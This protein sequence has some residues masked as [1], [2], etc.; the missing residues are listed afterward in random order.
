MKGL[1]V[2]NLSGNPVIKK[3]R[4]Y[5]KKMIVRLKRLTYLDD[6]PVF[7]RDRA[8]AEAWDVGGRDAE[9]R[10]H[11]EWNKKDR[12]K[13]DA[14][15]N[16]LRHIREKAEEKRRLEGREMEK[17]TVEPAKMFDYKIEGVDM[18]DD[19]TKKKKKQPLMILTTVIASVLT[20]TILTMKI[21]K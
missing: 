14:S 8:C 5:R 3:I 20:H 13:I 12:A 18:E 17:S 7:P 19:I 4:F 11:E 15:I 21:L 6:R 2:L 16:Y 10:E 9:R 1:K